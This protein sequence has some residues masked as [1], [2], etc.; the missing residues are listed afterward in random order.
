MA[1]FVS[2]KARYIL[3]GLVICLVSGVFVAAVSYVVAYRIAA[4]LT[5][6][7]V[8]EL[9]AGQARKFDFWFDTKAQ[10]V[11][12]LAQDI[13]AAGDFSDAHLMRL[14]LR[15]MELYHKEVLDFYI[16]FIDP[17]RRLLSG[18]GWIPPADYDARSRPWFKD[19]IKAD[20]VVFTEPYRDAMTD[21]LVVTVAKTMHH[22]GRPVAVVATD[23]YIT[24]LGQV[25]RSFSA[26]P[27]SYALL[28]DAKG[29]VIAHPQKALEPSPDGLRPVEGWTDHGRLMA[30]L[31]N[32]GIGK[33][34]DLHNP[35]GTRE[36]YLFSRMERSGWLFGIAVDRSAYRRPLRLLLAGFAAALGL[37]ILIG[38]L[39]MYRLVGRMVSPIH[40]LTKTVTSF[41]GDNLAVRTTVDSSDEVG[42]LGRAFNTMADTIEGYSRSLENMV[43]ERTRQL[44]E[45]NETIMESIDYARRLQSTIL[46][47]L[48]A[49]LGLDPRHCFSIWRPRDVVG[50]DM[51][52]CRRTGDRALLAVADCT[53]HGVP[54]ALVAMTLST[55]FDA[56]ARELEWH[57]P[58]RFVQQAHLRLKQTLQQDKTTIWVNDGADAAILF[59][60]FGSRRLVFC[61]AHFPVFLRD[62]TG[63]REI[64]GGRRSIGYTLDREAHFEDIEIDWTDPLCLYLTT[65]GLLDQNH[66]P[67][68]GGMGRDGF[69]RLLADMAALPIADQQAQL[70]AEIDRRLAGAAQRDD[71][72]VVGLEL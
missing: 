8:G 36:Y 72:C 29:R 42:Q 52:W 45:K 19:A 25:V 63:V 37:S 60:D 70:A 51:F 66:A 44:R 32:G 69:R 56:L 48:P 16:G 65:D 9:A 38:G 62:A 49:V 14:I 67:G 58:A 39:V 54:G 12:G 46:P 71:I 5:D 20:K 2:L 40:A 57:S 68:Q 35:S 28:L 21:E 10:L 64:R 61:G 43:E 13:E 7:Y 47:D 59:I 55:T 15:K 23:I 26:G 17:T 4:D 1:R 41:S 18:I 6:K 50:G 24:A 34:L 27:G 33:R 31:D 22:Q 3:A 30:A 11:E 53:G